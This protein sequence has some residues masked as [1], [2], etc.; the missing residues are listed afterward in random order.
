MQA[1]TLTRQKQNYQTLWT[2]CQV[3]SDLIPKIQGI[4]AKIIEFR[5]YYEKVSI[6]FPVPWW[7]VG[8]IHASQSFVPVDSFI[9]GII[10]KLKALQFERMPADPD[11]PTLLFAF[12]AY[13]EFRGIVNDI[14]SFIWTGTS[15]IRVEAIA[16]GVGAIAFYMYHAEL[17]QTDADARQHQGGNVKLKVL[18]PTIFKNAPL[19]SYQLKEH[20]KM[21]V[22]P[23]QV[24]TLLEDDPYEDGIHVRVVL[25]DSSL[26]GKN[27]WFCYR[28]HIEIQ[29][30]EP[31]NQPQDQPES[32]PEKSQ[33]DRGSLISIPGESDIHL[34][35]PVLGDGCHFNWA[36]MTKGGTR[37]PENR[38]V[39]DNM[40]KVTQALEEVRELYDGKPITI[41][42]GYRP[43]AVNRRVGGSSKSRHIAGDA[44][45][46]VIKGVPPMQAHRRLESWWGDK[47]G[48]ASASSF[49]H[50]DCRGYRARW[51]YGR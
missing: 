21:S 14:S 3:R 24:F 32:L 17:T 10:N 8:C 23:G 12:D 26:G 30:C 16:P 35:D 39:V 22:N 47:G 28:Q 27:V 45:D 1:N 19:Q 51:S 50:I 43:P 34:F 44:I 5:P 40:K 46:F 29:G 36:E 4:V 25:A 42:S 13:N 38:Q 49:T 9:L 48:I 31:S 41:N 20:E 11:I 6:Q 37:L 2:T 7:W 33:R 18:S 15:H